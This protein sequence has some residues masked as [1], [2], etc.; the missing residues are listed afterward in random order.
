MKTICTL[1]LVLPNKM[2][3]LLRPYRILWNSK[4]ADEDELVAEL[5]QDGCLSSQGVIDAMKATDRKF[6]CKY[7]N[8][9]NSVDKNN[10]IN[11]ITH[12]QQKYACL[13]TKLQI[14][15]TLSSW[16]AFLFASGLSVGLPSSGI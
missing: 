2:D 6:Y 4:N 7:F 13:I 15:K 5:Q 16:N 3:S 8:N 10:R 11:L 12:I 14:C 1:L 9:L